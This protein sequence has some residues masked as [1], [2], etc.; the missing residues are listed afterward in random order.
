KSA[1]MSL[2]NV[3][4]PTRLVVRD[5]FLTQ[6]SRE[7]MLNLRKTKGFDTEIKY[8]NTINRLNSMANPRNIER[9]PSGI[10]FEFSM[11]YKIIDDDDEK[12]FEHV[13]DALR[14]VELDGIG[15]GVSRGN[16]Q[17]RFD[18]MVDGVKT[19]ISKRN[20]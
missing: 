9:I 3:A 19:D 13:L 1:D 5:A 6:E 16:G 10:K 4:G 15:G 12:N 20:V 14:L 7:K 18:I 8:E 11:T 2:E 17:V